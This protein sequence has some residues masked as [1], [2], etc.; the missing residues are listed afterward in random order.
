[1]LKIRVIPIILIDG[2]SALKTINFHQ[3]RN[4]GSP[5]TAVKTYN[6]RNVDELIILD[7]DASKQNRKIDYF[8][9]KDMAKECFM[10]LTIGGGVESIEDIQ[11]LLNVGADKVAINTSA[12]KKGLSF[13]KK[14][15]SIFGSQCIV[16]SIDY[17][18]TSKGFFVFDHLESKTLNLELCYWSKQLELAGVGEILINSVQDDGSMNGYDLDAIKMV[19]GEV[20]VPVVVAG[21]GNISSAID[22]VKIGA[23]AVAA[24][25]IFNFTHIT[26]N[27]IRQ[28]LKK[29]GYPTRR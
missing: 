18:K 11:A 7:I 29:N 13:I 16:G 24:S 4:L 12:L 17:I 28:E 19:L 9:I 2:F 14:S 27:D 20:N 26:P 3:R 6:T 5:I 1:M 23:S 15:A 25:S 22:V 8:L 21:G 10:P